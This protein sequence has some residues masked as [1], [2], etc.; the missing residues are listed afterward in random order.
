MIGT[1]NKMSN[2]PL[3][4]PQKLD[5]GIPYYFLIGKRY[6]R[7]KYEPLLVDIVGGHDINTIRTKHIGSIFLTLQ[8]AE[9]Q[10]KILKEDD[11][12]KSSR[13]ERVPFSDIAICK[14]TIIKTISVN[15]E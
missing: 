12:P 4:K 3:T 8:H 6:A 5:A 15:G 11:K 14:L 13:R 9:R 2:I 7:Q 1:V 10:G